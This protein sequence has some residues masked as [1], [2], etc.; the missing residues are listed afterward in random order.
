MVAIKDFLFIQIFFVLTLNLFFVLFYF[1]SDD[2][3]FAI[4]SD[5]YC[6]IIILFLWLQGKKEKFYVKMRFPPSSL[7]T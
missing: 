1:F 3:F 6:F 5:E 2:V 4:H 7:H